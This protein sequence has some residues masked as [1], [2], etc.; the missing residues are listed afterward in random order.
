MSTIC[1]VIGY[2]KGVSFFVS[3]FIVTQIF[4][5]ESKAKFVYIRTLFCG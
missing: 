5:V 2:I 1:F 3:F 4:E